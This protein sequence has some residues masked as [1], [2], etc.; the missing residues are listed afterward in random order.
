MIIGILLNNKSYLP[1]AYAYQSFLQ[2]KNLE[3]IL[4]YKETELINANV[5]ILFGGF[6][7]N[8]KYK[9]KKYIIDYASISTPPFVKIKDFIKKKLNFKP[10]L[11]IFNSEFINNYY[12]FNDGIPFLI[13][14]AGIGDQFL[15]ISNFKIKKY[16]IIYSGSI[17]SRKGLKNILTKYLNFGCSILIVG[18][19]S[20]TFKNY[21]Q[22]YKKIFF[23][24]RIPYEKMADFYCQC[25]Y[26][27]NY[28]P[29]IFPYN[30]QYSLKFLEYSASK[31]KV[32]S[33]RTIFMD[34]LSK[35]KKINFIY[36]DMINNLNDLKNFKF[37]DFDIEQ[38]KWNTIL[39]N[40]KFDQIIKNLCAE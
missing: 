9:N 38:Y 17:N 25:E 14:K 36:D 3:V 34:Q 22:K 11:R 26:G 6:F 21:F 31:L 2:K 4:T 1:E 39:E 35:K 32:I 19:V 5:I 18:S 28:I 29:N 10:N 7:I 24:G 20:N 37:E 15:N 12:N 30:Y 13:R 33:N 40:I 27:L 23:T 8:K 16:D